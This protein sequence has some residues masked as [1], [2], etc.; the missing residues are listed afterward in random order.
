M[1]IGVSESLFSLC[2]KLILEELE[3]FHP[4]LQHLPRPIQEAVQRTRSAATNKN[5]FL[6]YDASC[7]A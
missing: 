7:I 2:L 1:C 5:T 4:L 6:V 3:L